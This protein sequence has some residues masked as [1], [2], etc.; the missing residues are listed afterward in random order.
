MKNPKAIEGDYIETK[1]DH[2]FFD[3]KGY[4]HPIDRKICFIRFYPDKDGDRVKYNT[5][6]KKVYALNERYLLLRDKFPRYLFYSTPL[7]LELQGVKN[8]DIKKIY[9]PRDCFRNLKT[10][11]NLSNIEKKSKELCDLFIDKGGIPEKSIGISGSLMVGLSKISSDI[12][13]IIYGTETSITF[14][15]K[16]R[17]ILRSSKICRSYNLDEYR[18][19]YTW[20]VGGSDIQF[21]DFIRSEKR[22]LH[23]GKFH[24]KDFYIRYVKSPEDWKGSYYDY[25]Y[26]NLGRIKIKA[27]II[28]STESIFTPCSYKIKVLLLLDSNLISNVIYL[29]QINEINSFRGRFSEQAKDGEI[30]IVEGKLEKVNYRNQEEYYRILLSDQVNDKM[31]ILS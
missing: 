7:D 5:H 31:L 10:K 25:K 27:K 29:D 2:L 13:L 24:E 22:K 9:T 19:H 8:E 17:E 23:Q 21:K 16:L 15:N 4:H 6:Y 12:D 11:N 30:V 20:R 18:S 28:D 26:R 1:K 3:V 14:Q